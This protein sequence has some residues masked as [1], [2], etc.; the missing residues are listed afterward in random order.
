MFTE[1]QSIVKNEIFLI[2]I[3]GLEASSFK[4]KI[5]RRGALCHELFG[6]WLILQCIIQLPECCVYLLQQWN[7]G[8]P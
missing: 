1:P 8:F 3:G 6:I 5:L 2:E 7:M 4:K